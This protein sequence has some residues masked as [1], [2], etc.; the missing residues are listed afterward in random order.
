MV[1]KVKGMKCIWKYLKRIG[2]TKKKK[3]TDTEAIKQAI[4]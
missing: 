1:S 4:V 3:K 2:S